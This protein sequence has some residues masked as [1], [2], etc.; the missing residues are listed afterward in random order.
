[1][2][3]LRLD[4][5]HQRDIL[6]GCHV[7]FVHSDNMTFAYWDLDEGAL[8]PEHAH[9]HEQVCTVI[10]GE[11]KLMIDGQTRVMT[12]GQVGVIPSNAPHLARAR[13]KCFVQDVFWPIREDYR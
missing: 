6:P 8:I 5:L 12:R 11:L 1:M 3:F 9:P 4:D 2:P 13:T 10:E 7:R